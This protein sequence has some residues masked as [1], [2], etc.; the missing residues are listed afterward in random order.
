M[1]HI[2]LV[3]TIIVAT[4]TA[5]A[6]PKRAE[7]LQYIRIEE[8]STELVRFVGLHPT[9]WNGNEQQ[10]PNPQQFVLLVRPGTSYEIVEQ[11]IECPSGKVT[12]VSYAAFTADGKETSKSRKVPETVAGHLG[13]AITDQRS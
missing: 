11:R 6:A 2:F 5:A 10:R 9:R 12:N 1:K 4:G 8:P 13:N 3:A 7:E